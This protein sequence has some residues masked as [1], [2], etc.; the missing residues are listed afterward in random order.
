VHHEADYARPGGDHRQVGHRPCGHSPGQVD[1]VEPPCA[2]R[3]GDRGGAAAGAA[4]HDDPAILGEV[5][6][7]PGHLAHGQQPG[8]RH[9]A[10]LPLAR[11][12]HVQQQR[13]RI[14]Q[15]RRRARTHLG[16]GRVGAAS[17]TTRSPAASQ[18]R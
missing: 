12:A 3:L 16:R 1:R 4:R 10:G 5:A 2:Q 6:A 18:A 14:H 13:T 11:L 17:C 15:R 9:V 8:L 7:L